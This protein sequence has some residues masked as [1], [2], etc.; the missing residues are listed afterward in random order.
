M[1]RLTNIIFKIYI[2]I[3]RLLN[4]FAERAKIIKNKV[5]KIY[6]IEIN[7][8]FHNSMQQTFKGKMNL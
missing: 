7:N 8:I 2:K 6:L 4:K 1:P 5:I 3:F